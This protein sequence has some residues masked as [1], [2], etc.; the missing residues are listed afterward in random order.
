MDNKIDSILRSKYMSLFCGL[1]NG[2]CAIQLAIAGHIFFFIF[3]GLLS[4][5][6][7]RNYIRA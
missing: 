2:Y 5:Y 3:L 4:A 1:L 7:F 6:C